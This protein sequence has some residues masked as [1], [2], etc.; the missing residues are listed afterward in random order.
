MELLY[1]LSYFGLYENLPTIPYLVK[2]FNGKLF[3]FENILTDAHG[4][5]V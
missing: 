1:H 5:H 2:L 4:E 3:D